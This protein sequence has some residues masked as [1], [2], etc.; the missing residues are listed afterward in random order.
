VDDVLVGTNRALVGLGIGVVAAGGAIAWA[1]SRRHD[2]AASERSYVDA[3]DAPNTAGSPEPASADG[4][5]NLAVAWW[6]QD[7][8]LTQHGDSATLRFQ[9]TISNLGGQPVA[10]RPGDRLEYTLQRQDELGNLGAIVA[11]GSAPLDRADI[12]PFPVSEGVEIGHSIQTYGVTLAPVTSM[13]PQTAAI[14]GAQ[15][16]SQ[17]LAIDGATKGLYAL[18]Q[19]IVH[20]DGT[21]DLEPFDD[22]R[23]TEFY[24]DGAGG[25]LHADSRYAG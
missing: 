10:I 8:T 12:E 14:I 9:S 19:Q 21:T 11:R 5:G 1:A 2:A 23:L 25:I 17:S 13:A 7:I 15:H 6:P 20:A 16:P 22:V 3:K 24:L 18:R 4:P